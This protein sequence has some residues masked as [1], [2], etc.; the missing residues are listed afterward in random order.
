MQPENPGLRHSRTFQQHL[1]VGQR[2]RSQVEFDQPATRLRD[3]DD[4]AAYRPARESDVGCV[5]D[6]EPAVWEVFHDAG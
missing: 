4:G 3:H 2:L 6:F 5:G 1:D